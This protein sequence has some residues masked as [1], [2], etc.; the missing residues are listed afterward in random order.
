VQAVTERWIDTLPVINDEEA[1][2]YAYAYLAQLID[3]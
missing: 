3:A 1:A 2:P